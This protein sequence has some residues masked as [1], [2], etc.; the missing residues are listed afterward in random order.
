MIGT[1]ALIVRVA[2]DGGTFAGLATLPVET[3]FHFALAG[4]QVPLHVTEPVE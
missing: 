4:T 1:V 3:M 2:S